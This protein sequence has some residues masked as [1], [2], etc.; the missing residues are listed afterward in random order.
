MPLSPYMMRLREALGN[1]LVL[2]PSVA[3]IVHNPEGRVLLVRSTS[4]HQWGLPAGAIEPGET[5]AD[6]VGRELAEETGLRT[7]RTRLRSGARR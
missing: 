5:P 7:T 6:A 4:T 2:V 3:G 1:A